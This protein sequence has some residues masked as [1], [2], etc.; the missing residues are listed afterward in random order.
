MPE[1]RPSPAPWIAAGLLAVAGAAVLATH[2]TY[3]Q[4]PDHHDPWAPLRIDA[5]PGWLTRFKLDRLDRDPAACRAVLTTSKLRWE[6]M[7]DR[8][9]APGC[10]FRNAV[11]VARMQSEVSGPFSLSCRAAVSLA[12][13]EQHV[14]RPEAERHLAAPLRRID[15]FGSYACRNVYGRSSGRRSQ[16]ATADA[17]DISGFIVGRRR[18]SIARDWSGDD[19]EAAFLHAIHQGACRFFDGVLGPGYNAAHADHFH[20]DRGP[21]RV[22]R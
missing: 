13:W 6:A 10:G 16:H 12:L 18:I 19:A 17:L 8:D 15:H 14:L 3:W 7:P 2:G 11:I 22:C 9:T 5:Q 4:V 21:Y 1:R 20:L